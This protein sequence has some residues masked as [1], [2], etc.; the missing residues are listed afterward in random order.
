[1]A[2]RSS[3]VL[4]VMGVLALGCGSTNPTS[5]LPVAPTATPPSG[6]RYLLAGE[7]NAFFLRECCL[8]S[9]IGLVRVGSIDNWLNSSEFAEQARASELIAFLWWQ[10]NGDAGMAPETYAQK[11]RALIALVHA[12][13]PGLPVRI[14]EIPDTPA[15]AS[16]REAQRSVAADPGVEL[17]PTAD[18]PL[19]ADG[20]FFTTGYMTVRDRINR[21]LGR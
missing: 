9:A 4:L 12:A 13:S 16:V 5:P 3:A 2:S 1:M 21:S 11:L 6:P 14:I 18:L 20:H 15:R 17:I 7:S 8:T 10:G 19:N